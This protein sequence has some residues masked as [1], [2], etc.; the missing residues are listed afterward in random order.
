VEKI[1]VRA[2][3]WGAASLCG[4]TSPTSQTAPC[5]CGPDVGNS[6][7]NGAA[8]GWCAH[9]GPC[10]WRSADR[11]GRYGFFILA[12]PAGRSETSSIAAANSVHEL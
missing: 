9:A 5:G 3:E 7:A 10:M 11:I 1:V 4:L 2:S 6:G 8:C 12:L